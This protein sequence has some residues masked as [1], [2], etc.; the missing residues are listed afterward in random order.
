MSPPRL[1]IVRDLPGLGDLLCA[2]PATAAPLVAL[3]P[4][5]IDP[6]RHWPAEHFAAVGDAMVEAGARVAVTGTAGERVLVDAVVGT[7]RRPALDLVGRLTINGLAGLQSR[8]RLVVANDTGPLHLVAAVGAATVGIYWCGY[9][10]NGGPLSRTRHRPAI[11]WQLACSVCG[12]D[13]TRTR[14]PH[15]ASFVAGV[16]VP[17]VIGQ[18]SDLLSVRRIPDNHRN[19]STPHLIARSCCGRVLSGG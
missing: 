3:H 9:L 8:C 2:V 5:T 18:A 15:Q 11:S 7:M 4:H 12:A 10:I 6:R 13:A 16:P 14:C 1:A 19:K 17:D